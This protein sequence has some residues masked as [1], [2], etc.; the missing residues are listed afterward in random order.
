[1]PW[2]LKELIFSCFICRESWSLRSLVHPFAHLFIHC[3]SIF[4]KPPRCCGAHQPHATDKAENFAGPL[5]T[6]SLQIA[7]SCLS[8]N[9]IKNTRHLL[10]PRSYV[11]NGGDVEGMRGRRDPSRGRCRLEEGLMETM[12]LGVGRTLR[13]H[14]HISEPGPQGRRG[15]CL[16]F[17]S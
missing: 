1:M 2:L 8:N 9:L 6:L 14:L 7:P 13:S 15:T 3:L 11:R 16:R 4:T 5:L 12:L 10:C 17:L